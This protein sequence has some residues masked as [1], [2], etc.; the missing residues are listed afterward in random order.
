[1]SGEYRDEG[2]RLLAAAVV[3][4][5]IKDW[6]YLCKT[7]SDVMSDTKHYFFR[8]TEGY[9]T[10]GGLKRFFESEWC[11]ILCGNVDPDLILA[12][13]NEERIAASQSGG[14]FKK[15]AKEESKDI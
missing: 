12:K 13:L 1:M 4:Q 7:A 3:E 8:H 14:Q 10:F 6:R 9:A 5:A 15:V 2:L 11:R